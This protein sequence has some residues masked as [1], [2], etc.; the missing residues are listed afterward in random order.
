M[1]FV[2][3]GIQLT[4]LR[5]L[6]D[7]YADD[8]DGCDDACVE[9]DDDASPECNS[10]Q[11]LHAAGQFDIIKTRLVSHSPTDAQNAHSYV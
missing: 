6:Y 1:L 4:K 8:D 3:S 5:L 2:I 11:N 7:D 9:D 10:K